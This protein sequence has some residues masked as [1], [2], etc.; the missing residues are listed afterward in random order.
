MGSAGF[1]GSHLIDAVLG[2][3]RHVR[4]ADPTETSGHEWPT[5]GKPGRIQQMMENAET[6]ERDLVRAWCRP[7]AWLVPADYAVLSPLFRALFTM[8][9]TVTSLLW[10]LSG[11]D[12]QAEPLEDRLCQAL[13]AITDGVVPD[14]P[15][16]CSE[17]HIALRG[18][19]TAKIYCVA[20]SL[21]AIDWLP[22]D[23]FATLRRTPGGIG[24]ALNVLG[25]ET[26][27]E[28]QWRGF[29]PVSAVPGPLRPILADGAYVRC[30]TIHHGGYPVVAICERFPTDLQV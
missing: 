3:G 23:F 22:A 13:S 9:G 7:P 24:A 2:G 4:V 20:S 19:V 5:N 17:R 27:R 28:I 12:I 21:I 14:I 30:Y 15:A 1:P 16:S 18:E 8:D 10:A 26:R 29:Q 25:L 11:E 6:P